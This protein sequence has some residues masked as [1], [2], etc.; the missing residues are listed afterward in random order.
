[1]KRYHY[2]VFLLVA[3]T[4]GSWLLVPMTYADDFVDDIYYTPTQVLKD[5][6]T[7]ELQPVYN[8]KVREIV[9]ITDTTASAQNDTIVR[10]VIRN[11]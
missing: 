11:K 1:M 8:R 4:L 9:F 2:I 5:T 10:A 7:K 3:L 6:T